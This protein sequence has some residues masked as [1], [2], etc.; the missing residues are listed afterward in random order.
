MRPIWLSSSVAAVSLAL[1]AAGPAL[2]NPTTVDKAGGKLHVVGDGSAET[3]SVAADLTVTPNM[4][5]VSGPSGF[6]A[7]AGCSSTATSVTCPASQVSGI[8]LDTAGGADTIDEKSKYQIILLFLGAGSGPVT[9]TGG[10]GDDT[11]NAVNTP[12]TF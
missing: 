3:Y 12:L 6:S 7:P 2:A 4:Y 5:T 11:L 1:L 9:A 8:T 10:A